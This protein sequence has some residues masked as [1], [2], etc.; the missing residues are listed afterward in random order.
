MRT[1]KLLVRLPLLPFMCVKWARMSKEK[2]EEY[3]VTCT[4]SFLALAKGG[5]VR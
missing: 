4:P 3:L 2:R 1:I 5:D